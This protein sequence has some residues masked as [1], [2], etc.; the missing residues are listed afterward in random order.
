MHR[1]NAHLIERVFFRPWLIT[2]GGYAAVRALVDRK[3]NGEKGDWEAV[4]PA[5]EGLE[6]DGNGIA[7]IEVS[8]TLCRNVG[9]LEACCG[10]YDYDWLEEGLEE[11]ML[12][13][14]RGVFL[15]VDSPGG[16]AE[17]CCE[18]GEIL[19]DVARRVPVVVYS[20]GQV[21]SAAYA[22]ACNATKLFGA[23]SSTWGSIG[24]IIP[25][26]D[27]EA[28]EAA[29][30][31]AWNPVVNEGGVLKGTGHGPVLTAAERASLQQ[32]VDDSFGLF[33]ETVLKNRNVPAEAMSGGLYLAARALSF[34]LV[35]AIGTE[36][37]AYQNLLALVEKKK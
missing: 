20:E 27:S 17:G 13:G 25:W 36:D 14:C 35:D 7:H 15:E 2:P 22:I 31:L 23:A 33:K 34:N 26:R 28:A 19:A 1:K 11:A 9:P 6:I 29:A 32:L 24:C 30:G 21:A 37:A 3:M 12:A 10:A 18:A 8:G 5:R 16:S 4:M